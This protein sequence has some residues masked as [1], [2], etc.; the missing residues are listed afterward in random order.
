MQKK[1]TDLY[2]CLTKLKL[3]KKIDKIN[4]TRH[5]NET[6]SKSFRIQLSKWNKAA[7]T[8]QWKLL[9]WSF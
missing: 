7:Q 2:Q 4:L 1:D 8:S 9:Q 6:T 5:D 3:Y